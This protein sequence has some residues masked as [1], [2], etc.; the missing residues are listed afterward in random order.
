MGVD[1]VSRLGGDGAIE[2]RRCQDGHRVCYG[3]MEAQPRSN[4]Y[5]RFG[6]YSSSST[7][8]FS[9]FLWLNLFGAAG[10]DHI[11]FFFVP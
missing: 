3:G 7:L 5:N 2:R 6:S 9:S 4:I 1:A 8:D 11:L 10:L